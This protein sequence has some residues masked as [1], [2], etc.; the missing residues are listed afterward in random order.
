MIKFFCF[1]LRFAGEVDP[2]ALEKLFVN[3]GKHYRRMSFAVLELRQ[4][5][6]R[7]GCGGVGCGADGKSQQEF[8]C[9]Q[10]GVF[11]TQMIELQIL[12]GF[13]DDG[14]NKMNFILNSAK[15]F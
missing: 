2:Q 14:G 6:H 7:Q 15:V 11:G 12:N 4:L 10:S 13:D 3:V 1:V 8:V 5:F 9:V